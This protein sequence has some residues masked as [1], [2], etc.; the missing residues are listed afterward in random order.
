MRLFAVLAAVTAL[1][2]PVAAVAQTQPQPAPMQPSA[3]PQMAPA[4][5]QPQ[6]GMI[7]APPQQ[8]LNTMLQPQSGLQPI[9]PSSPAPAAEP[10]AEEAPPAA[11]PVG[12]ILLSQ[13]AAQPSNIVPVTSE[14]EDDTAAETSLSRPSPETRELGARE[15]SV[16]GVEIT[17]ENQA[18]Q[19]INMAQS[20]E[21]SPI[22]TNLDVTGAQNMLD[23]PIT[24]EPEN[25]QG[26]NMDLDPGL[27]GTAEGEDELG[28]LPEEPVLS[29]E[30]QLRIRLKEIEQQG[31]AEA[32]E[33]TKRA[34][35][36]LETYQ[37]RDLIRRL[38]VTQ[39]AIQKPV[40][41]PPV[42]HNV[43]KTI[44]FDPSAKS[45]TI[46]LYVGNVTALNIV[47][48][49]GA[50][51]PI[52]D[53]AYG[54][55]FDIKPPDAGG[56]IL[57]ITPLRDYARGNMIIR[58]LKLNTPITLLLEAGGEVVHHRFDARIPEY[59]PNARL[60]IVDEGIKMVAGDSFVNSVLE[61]VTPNSGEKLKVEGLDARTSAY[62]V[63][64]TLYVR[65]PLTMLSPSWRGSATS[66]DGMN[67]YVLA[68]APVLLF[69][70]DGKLVRARI[71]APS[72]ALGEQ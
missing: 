15:R 44:S 35:L 39:E 54:G 27:V 36:P 55:N 13:D 51:W 8:E 26:I 19:P 25:N 6:P 57:R 71:S 41:K 20:D 60:P 18:L 16:P 34:V 12:D 67:V 29:Y 7:A 72:K 62:R 40:L 38:K 52:V 69:S 59:G 46:Q 21:E 61:G 47:D 32:F 10:A 5:N 45:E 42:P 58:L 17:Q 2:A 48:V 24:Q 4:G 31:R 37:I 50:P 43:V 63:G 9:Q 22:I 70:D 33:R 3:Q 53:V 11:N 66:A 65:T 68:E 28:A 14:S 30:E 1:S 56:S 23:T 64:T 49:T